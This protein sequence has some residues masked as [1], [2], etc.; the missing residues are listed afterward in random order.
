LNRRQIRLLVTFDRRLKVVF[1]HHDLVIW[2]LDE[3]DSARIPIEMSCGD[4]GDIPGEEVKAEV[5]MP[6]ESL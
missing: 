2:R 4:A 3:R 5:L 6:R 1:F